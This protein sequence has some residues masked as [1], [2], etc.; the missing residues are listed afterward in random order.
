MNKKIL[1]GAVAA[2]TLLGGGIANAKPAT[3]PGANK[4]QCFDGTTDGNYGGTCT[5]PSNGAKGSAVL[6]LNSSNPSGDYAGAYVTNTNLAGAAPS[7]VTQLSYQYTGTKTPTPTELSLNVPY[8]SDGGNTADQY[9][10]ADAAYCPGTLQAS[11][12][13]F[14]DVLHD[15]NCVL[16][17]YTT[18]YANWSAFAAAHSTAKLVPGT[19]LPFVIAE[20][21]PSDVAQTWTVSNVT[22]GKPGTQK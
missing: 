5:L 10:F 22:L 14:V 17:D 19:S 7:Q 12:A 8:A 9:L 20:R 1:G 16:W 18:S 13:M 4:L 21:T 11:G 3:A 2:L 15:S 6:S